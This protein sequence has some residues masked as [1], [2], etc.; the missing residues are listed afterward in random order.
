MSTNPDEQPDRG[1][2]GELSISSIRNGVRIVVFVLL[3]AQMVVAI[4]MGI[5]AVVGSSG[6]AGSGMMTGFAVVACLSVLAFGGPALYLAIN[7]KHL[8]TAFIL[9]LVFPVGLLYMMSF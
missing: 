2:E 7:W 9:S 5:N 6:G 1:D 8:K 3:F 4:G